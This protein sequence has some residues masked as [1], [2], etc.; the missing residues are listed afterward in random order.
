M[1]KIGALV[2]WFRHRWI[3]IFQRWCLKVLMYFTS[4]IGLH[5]GATE[6]KETPIHV[7]TTSSGVT[8]NIKTTLQSQVLSSKPDLT[9][10]CKTIT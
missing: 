6:E 4:F 3:A 2:V 7:S 1:V 10:D 9:K 8:K 5:I